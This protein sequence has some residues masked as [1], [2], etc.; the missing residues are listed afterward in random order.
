MLSWDRDTLKLIIILSPNIMC[1][2]T[3]VLR[4]CPIQLHSVLVSLNAISSIT[5]VGIKNVYKNS[6]IKAVGL[7]TF[8]KIVYNVLIEKTKSIKMIPYH[9][10]PKLRNR[11]IWNHSFTLSA[12]LIAYWT[13][14]THPKCIV[15]VL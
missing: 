4:L 1:R 6:E 11:T 13:T 9:Y 7:P 14:G 10:R 5:V 2:L 3:C 15:V 8:K 12:Q